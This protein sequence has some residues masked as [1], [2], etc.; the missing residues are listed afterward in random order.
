MKFRLVAA[1]GL[2]C[3][4]A[5]GSLAASAE[6]TAAPAP[7]LS[8]KWRIEVSGGANSDGHLLFRVTPDQGTP[9]D[10]KVEIDDGRGENAVAGD[11]KRAMQK[12]LDQKTYKAEV[13]DGEDVLVKKKKGPDFAVELVESTVKNTK[14]HIEKE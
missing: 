3:S 2:A 9:V 6:D 4:L 12:A 1:L 8:N 10:V 14:V 11:I 7:S 5:L 13:D